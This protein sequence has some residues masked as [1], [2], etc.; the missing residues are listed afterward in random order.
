[1]FGRIFV[2]FLAVFSIQAEV[3]AVASGPP[4]GSPMTME[5]GA[6]NGFLPCAAGVLAPDF[7]NSNT[8]EAFNNL[9]SKPNAG[10]TAVLTGHGNSGLICT[11]NGDKCGAAGTIMGYWN[12]TAWGAPSDKISGSF[13]IFRLLGCDVGADQVGADFL[14][15]MA[16]HVQ[17]PVT[18]P[19]YLVWCG[20]GKVWLDPKAKWQTATPTMK[21]VPIPKPTFAFAASTQMKFNVG[22][23]MVTVP[24]SVVH[25]SGFRYSVPTVPGEF[26]S[27]DDR[28]N[29]DVKSLVNFSAPFQPGG[30]PAAIITAEFTLEFTT[31]EKK[32][33]K[34]FAVY[35]DEV[36]QDT[37]SADTFYEISSRLSERLRLLRR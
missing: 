12:E 28:M 11:G 27:A 2:A 35:N 17:R 33:S 23:R 22:G 4:W 6:D 34:R 24:A 36:A 32:I 13:Y 25:I 10:A 29:A 15:L 3:T 9:A 20:N 14:F 8:T 31:G 37:T 1:M 26:R 16:K 7:R 30:V 5:T 19:T 21:P 18:A